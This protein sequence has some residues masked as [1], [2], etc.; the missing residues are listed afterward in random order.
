MPGG[1]GSA[2]EALQYQRSLGFSDPR[3]GILHMQHKLQVTHFGEETHRTGAEV[4]RIGDQ[5]L[6]A[7]PSNSSDDTPRARG[8]TK[9]WAIGLGRWR[10]RSERAIRMVIF[11]TG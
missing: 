8:S 5:Q 6:E 7:L 4:E 9:P 1:T 2:L 11:N 10:G 3:A